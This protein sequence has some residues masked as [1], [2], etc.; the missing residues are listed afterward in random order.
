MKS[1]H[2]IKKIKRIKQIRRWKKRSLAV[3]F[4]SVFLIVFLMVLMYTSLGVKLITTVLEKVMP[5][6]QIEQVHGTLYDLKLDGFSMKL[7]GVDVK[8]D[9]AELSLSGLCLIQGKICVKNLA[10]QNVLV[11]IHTDQFAVDD[12]NTEQPIVTERSVID[13]PLPID[14]RQ[15]DFANVVVNVDDMHFALSSFKG[16]ANWVNEKIYIF[17]T[18]IMDIEA[19]FPDQPSTTVAK[20]SSN[21]DL[22]ISQTINDIFN[23]PLITTL[24]TVNIPLDIYIS[25]LKGNNWLLHIAGEDFRFNNIAIEG[26]TENNIINAKLVQTS[27]I[28]PYVNADISVK[29]KVILGDDWPIN[30]DIKV[31]TAA[32]KNQ[33]ATEISSKIAGKLLGKLAADMQISGFN[34]ADISTKIDFV[35]TYM[36]ITAKI[37]GTKIQW[38]ISGNADYLLKNFDVD[39]SGSVKDY[40]LNVKGDFY[41]DGLPTVLLNMQTDGSNDGIN[42]KSLTAKLPQGEVTTSGTVNWVNALQWTAA[43]NFNK[44]DLTKEIPNYP[45]LLNGQVKTDGSFSPTSWVANL[46]D[47]QLSGNINQAPLNASGSLA[48]TSSQFISAN[49]FN[50]KWGSN[51]IDVNGST[52]QEDFVAALNLTELSVIQPDLKGNITGHLNVHGSINQPMIKTNLLVKSFAWQDILLNEAQLTGNIEYTNLLKGRIEVKA[53]NFEMPNV[54]VDNADIVF[55]GDEKKHLLTINSEGKPVSTTIKLDGHLNKER[56]I[57]QGSLFEAVFAFNESNRW[58]INKPIQLKYNL[59]S[60]QGSV[61]A[62]CWVNGRSKMCLDKNVIISDHGEAS[63]TLSDIDLTLFEIINQGDTKIAG[64]VHGNASIKWSPQQKIP[65]I[66]ANIESKD[67]YVSQQIASQTLPIPFDLFVIKANINDQQAKLDWN[68]S[69]KDLGGFSGNIKVDSPTNQK[70]LSGKLIVDQLSLSIINPLLNS[71]EHASGAINGNLKFS[72]TLQDPYIVGNIG[73]DHSEI[74]TTQLPV[75]INSIMMDINFKGKSSVLKGQMNTKAGVVDIAG[76]AD[77]QDIQRWNAYVTV[78]GAA[79]EV[80]VPPMLTMSVIP[81][82]RVEADQDQIDLTGKISIPTAKIKVESLPPSTV[83]VSS[84]EVMLDANLQEIEPQ[85]SVMKINTKVFVSLGDKVSIDAFGLVARLSGGVYVTQTNKGLTVNGQI[86]IPQGRFK[87]YG[88]DLI[89]R[90]GEII[91]AGPADQPRLNIEAIRNPESIENNV[92]AGIRVTGLADDPKAEV[93]S[94][95]TMSQQEAL[96]YLL[97][98]QGLESGDQSENDMMTA[99]LIGLGTAQGGQ[100][101]GSLGD[102]VGIKNLSLD[103]QGVGD[104]QKVVVSGYILPNLQLKYGVGIFDALATFTL[105]YRLLPRLYLEAVS[106]V[107]QTV[108]LIYQFEF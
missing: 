40:H 89:V 65:S 41:G 74:K 35:E 75:D 24:P 92:V 91:F 94:E 88:Q 78:K 36:P 95:P 4:T 73:I 83:D 20:T 62:H 87:A 61:T 102:T 43:V 66:I 33:V 101:I 13:M 64:T 105:R 108:D 3:L 69:L 51:S 19:I 23:K 68:F 79:I 14:L 46:S 28:T 45:I 54:T 7:D 57:W 39:L 47:M 60:Q 30:A 8:I 98:G 10:A 34:Q 42:I 11:N 67:V 38:P 84:D 15:V 103:T 6:I 37:T 9:Q 56:T 80:S 22:S 31:K 48:I 104:S 58:Q 93:F 90:K 17:P 32:T 18:T 96:S 29:G 21:D 86:N 82:I 1:P 16:K 59:S 81:D 106:G 49:K 85:S 107:E 26:S 72:G 70:I 50:I 5:E 12:N 25:S 71:N 97:R 55:S 53:K 100:F 76:A 63:I 99:L 27:A 44:I 2:R 77:W 52:K